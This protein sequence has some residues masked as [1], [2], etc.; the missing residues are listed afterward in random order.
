[1]TRFGFF[2]SQDLFEALR[3]GSTIRSHISING[4]A[5][6]IKV[7]KKAFPP[8]PADIKQGI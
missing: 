8:M 2:F 3:G 4:E 5:P 7:L 6:S 1:M